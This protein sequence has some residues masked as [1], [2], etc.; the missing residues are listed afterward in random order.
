MAGQGVLY[1]RLKA[2]L[3]FYYKSGSEDESDFLFSRV[4]EEIPP[5]VATQ[6][7][8][9]SQNIHSDTNMNQEDSVLSSS[10]N[11]TEQSD[12]SKQ[13]INDIKKK[14]IYKPQSKF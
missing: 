13:L 7:S 11:K 3:E 14:K 12:E 2:G 9:S 1:I 5:A 6:V 4:N 10:I 8:S